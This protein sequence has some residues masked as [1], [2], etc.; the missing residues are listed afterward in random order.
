MV[1]IILSALIFISVLTMIAIQYKRENAYI[2]VI[3]A[4]D[5]LNRK[6][7]KQIEEL[8]HSYR[9]ACDERDKMF[10]GV[11]KKRRVIK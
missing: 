4:L 1:I 10:D 2:K 11:I 3:N 7:K 9:L 8:E 5:K 6:H